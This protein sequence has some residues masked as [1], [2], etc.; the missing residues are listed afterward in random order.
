LREGIPIHKWYLLSNLL[1]RDGKIKKTII[2][3]NPAGEIDIELRSNE[4]CL[5]VFC[6]KNEASM[7]DLEDFNNEIE[8]ARFAHSMTPY[9]ISRIIL[10]GIKS[11]K[12]PASLQEY[13]QE[14]TKQIN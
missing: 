5:H 7:E 3:E 13:I 1:L 14:Y 11:V 8:E 12:E 10:D 4:L 9:D 6:N 2:Y